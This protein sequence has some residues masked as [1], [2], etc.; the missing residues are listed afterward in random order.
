MHPSCEIGLDPLEIRRRLGRKTFGPPV[1]YGDDG[2]LFLS[3][4]ASPAGHISVIVTA[5]PAPGPDGEPD[6]AGGWWWHASLSRTEN[7][8]SAK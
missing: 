1:V 2:W 4:E 7:P 6:W 8:V 5:S 3:P